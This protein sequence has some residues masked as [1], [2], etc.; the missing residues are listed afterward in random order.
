MVASALAQNRTVKGEVVSASDGE[1]LVGATVVAVGTKTATTTDVDGKFVLSFPQS[2]S[3]LQFSYV[4]M[5]TQEVNV[6]SD[7]LK[8]ALEDANQLSE[9][10]VTGYGVT[11]KAAFTGAASTVSGTEIDKKN[12]VNFVKGLEGNVTGFQY[13]NSTSMPGA[14]G[15]VYVRGMGS[16]SSSSQPLYVIDGVPVNSDYDSMGD[17]NNYFDPMAAY[18]PND[19]ESV[20]VL[21]D[22]AATAIY[23]SRA[24]NGVIIITTKKGAEGKFELNIDV[25]QGLTS[26]ANNNMKYANAANTMKQFA[27]G[28]AARTGDSFDDC[29]NFLTD[30][31]EWDGISN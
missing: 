7:Y 5:K 19:I 13:N 24:A 6:T 26:V 15:A 11:K 23:G 28:Y 27:T 17:S 29:Y 20:T 1:P 4:G 9:V 30:Y 18:N 14:W 2:V 22:A 10:V 12:D 3:K 31:F 16:L 21:K 25:K 8:V